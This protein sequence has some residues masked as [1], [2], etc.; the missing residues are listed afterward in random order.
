MNERRP[1]IIEHSVGVATAML[2]GFALNLSGC[3]QDREVLD[4]EAPGVDLEVHED[5]DTGELTIDGQ[6]GNEEDN[7]EDHSTQQQ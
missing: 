3:D 6:L 7:G 5:T 4:V 2:L 1:G